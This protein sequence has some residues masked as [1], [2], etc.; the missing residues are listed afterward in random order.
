[1]AR[2]A[3]ALISVI[4]A[5]AALTQPNAVAPGRLTLIAEPSRGRGSPLRKVRPPRLPRR[6]PTKFELREVAASGS[7]ADL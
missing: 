6:E 2:L 1:L 4:N 3:V 5:S 7:A